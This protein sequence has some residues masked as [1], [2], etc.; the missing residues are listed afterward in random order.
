MVKYYCISNKGKL[1]KSPVFGESYILIACGSIIKFNPNKVKQVLS[2]GVSYSLNLKENSLVEIHYDFSMFR[3]KGK[4]A[5]E[6]IPSKLSL[7]E[8]LKNI[9]D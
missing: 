9:Q 6:N 4:K 1:V 5:I 2:K 3:R 8:F 7:E